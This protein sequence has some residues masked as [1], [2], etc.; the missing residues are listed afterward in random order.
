M[1]GDDEEYECSRRP[2]NFGRPSS[3]LE[4][5]KFGRGPSRP[6][7]NSLAR[8]QPQA[9]P[10]GNFNDD[11]EETECSRR[12]RNFG[13]LSSR[14]VDVN[15]QAFNDLRFQLRCLASL[16][17]NGVLKQSAKEKLKTILRVSH[18]EYLP[19]PDCPVLI[20]FDSEREPHFEFI[21]CP[22]QKSPGWPER[23]WDIK[24]ASLSSKIYSTLKVDIDQEDA[25]K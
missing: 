1:E 8:P 19:Q 10:A 9:S 3:G 12:P 4:K 20:R 6:L 18:P 14:E 15:Q 2:R 22:N 13:R 25:A 11:D 21:L 7:S 16:Y 5:V 23:E 17:E 24:V